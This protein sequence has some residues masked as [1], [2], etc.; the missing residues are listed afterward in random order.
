MQCMAYI[1]WKT[2][3]VTT[4]GL[5]PG[6]SGSIIYDGSLIEDQQINTSQSDPNAL[7]HEINQHKYFTNYDPYPPSHLSQYFVMTSIH[8]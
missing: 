1:L 2:L 7:K 8:P 5:D 3:Q 6:L 4:L